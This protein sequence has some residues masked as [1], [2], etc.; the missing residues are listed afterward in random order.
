[1]VA[2]CES[3]RCCRV[4]PLYEGGGAVCS[5]T[6]TIASD[7]RAAWAVAPFPQAILVPG[8]GMTK[9]IETGR[10][11]VGADACRVLCGRRSPGG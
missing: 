9:L 5:R 6:L 10:I 1:M 7:H 8:E 2:P 3:A 4:V 11:V